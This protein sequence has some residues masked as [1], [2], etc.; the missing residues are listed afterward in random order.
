MDFSQQQENISQAFQQAR[1]QAKLKKG[2]KKNKNKKNHQTCCSFCILQG[3]PSLTGC[4]AAPQSGPRGCH[5]DWHFTSSSSPPW[6]SKR[7][8]KPQ[9]ILNQFTLRYLD[10]NNAVYIYAYQKHNCYHFCLILLTLNVVQWLNA[11]VLKI[12]MKQDSR[13]RQW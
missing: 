7:K 10:S 2:E 8:P 5:V 13:N 9:Q 3:R 11:Q 1:E 6:M 12:S 4:P